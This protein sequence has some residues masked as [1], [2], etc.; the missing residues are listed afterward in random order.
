MCFMYITHTQGLPW[1]LS[2]EESASSAG[3]AGSVPGSVPGSGRSPGGG[4]AAP[5]S[6]LAGK[7]LGTED[8]GGLWS[9]E[10]RVR[11]N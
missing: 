1:L 7:I 8:P 11:H 5:C 9:M 10:R 4:V 3:D 2:G 6:V